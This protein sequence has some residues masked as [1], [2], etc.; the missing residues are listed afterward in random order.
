[1]KKP[2]LVFSLL[3]VILLQTSL[4]E[5]SGSSSEK[6]KHKLRLLFQSPRQPAA[7]IHLTLLRKRNTINITSTTAQPLSVK[8]R[9][10]TISFNSRRPSIMKMKPIKDQVKR[11][12]IKTYSYP[13]RKSKS[14]YSIKFRNILHRSKM[15]RFQKNIN[16]AKKKHKYFVL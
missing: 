6:E 12:K 14:K 7:N 13:A 11:P 3:L 8:P 16:E 5:N 9:L 10:K 15:G 2:P 1:M 4:S